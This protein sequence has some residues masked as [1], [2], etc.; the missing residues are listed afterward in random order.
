MKEYDKETLQNIEK[1]KNLHTEGRLIPFIGAGLSIRFSLPSSSGLINII[2]DELGWDPPILKQAGDIH[3]LA[4]YFI[5]VKGN[6]GELHSI[7]D[8]FFN[9]D[10]KL[11]EKS[12]AHMALAELQ[13]KRIYTTNWD[14]IIEIAFEIRGKPHKTIISIGDLTQTK[15]D[16]TQIVKFHGD[17]SDASSLVLPESS[18]FQRLEFETALDIK[19]RA[20][21]LENSLLFAG[22]DFSDI[23]MRYMLYKL[24]K[25]MVESHSTYIQPRA[26][27]VT[28]A[29]SD[30]ERRLLAKYG[31]LLVALDPIKKDESMD[32]FIESLV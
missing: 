24:K 13:P 10:R 21:I 28:F 7:L 9:V 16:E 11:I 31:V 29:P 18:Y 12:R 3:Q 17:F 20:D 19:L 23:N 14:R 15:R 8:R 27:M 2:A 26:I 32:D 6:I 30:V 25:L 5:E 22:Y 4:E 1:C